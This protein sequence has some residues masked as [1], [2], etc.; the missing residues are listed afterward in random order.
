MAA[1]T[2]RIV[3]AADPAASASVTPAEAI[4]ARL[5]S[6]PARGPRVQD[7]SRCSVA[8]RVLLIIA[9]TVPGRLPGYIAN[10]DRNFGESRTERTEH[11]AGGATWTPTR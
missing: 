9:N 10:I 2:E 8:S 11:P 6:G 1:A 3:T 7:G 5:C 4:S